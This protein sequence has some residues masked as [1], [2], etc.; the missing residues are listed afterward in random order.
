MKIRQQRLALAAL[1]ILPK[2]MLSHLAGRAAALRLPAPL[3]QWQI[4][5]FG[6]AVGV[7]F[8]EVRD[9]LASFTCLQD[10]FT[11]ALREGLRP[12][13]PAPDAV[14]APCDGSWGAAGTVTDGMLMQI[15]GRPYSLAGLLGDATLA[16]TFAGG[17]YATFYLS[18]RD[19]HRFHMPCA[20]R[21]RRATYIPGE[22][23]PVNRIGVEGIDGL[24]A[25]NERLCAFFSVAGDAIDLALVAVAAT[26][27][28][29]VHVTFDTLTTNTRGGRP[30][31]RSYD[32]APGLAKGAE[33]GRFEFGSTIVMIAARGLL[34]LDAA[35]P[36]TN[37]RLG[38]R[39]GTLSVDAT[40]A[41]RSGQFSVQGGA[42][43]PPGGGEPSR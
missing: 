39:I 14:V 33:W 42:P 31:A 40:C 4:R 11:R 20:A 36:G 43:S 41:T 26:L 23:W 28:G 34:T 24:F 19:Y 9:P 8:T 21:V 1:R 12:I 15:K 16:P 35:P 30:P 7:D 29:K 10:F 3:Q 25:E 13:D 5:A 38:E 37:V 32:P 22:L 6:R 18:P 2:H 27:V 17:P